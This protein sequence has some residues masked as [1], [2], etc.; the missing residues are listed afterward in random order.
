MFESVM[1]DLLYPL[2][3]FGCSDDE[4]VEKPR[5]CHLYSGI[6]VVSLWV[7]TQH[8]RQGPSGPIIDRLHETLL[9]KL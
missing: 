3:V 6:E 4:G 5:P 9:D 7:F 8:N 2:D 1:A